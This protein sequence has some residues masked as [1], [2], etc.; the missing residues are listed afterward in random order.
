MMAAQS[1]D[2]MAVMTALQWDDRLA[3]MMVA[4]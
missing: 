1:V 4:P 3:A 2:L